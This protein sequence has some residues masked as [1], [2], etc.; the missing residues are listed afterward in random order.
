MAAGYS[1]PQ[2]FV[3][4][5]TGV[6]SLA[7]AESLR[8][9]PF[10]LVV[11]ENAGTRASKLVRAL[12]AVAVRSCSGEINVRAMGGAE[13]QHFVALA[14]QEEAARYDCLPRLSSGEFRND[15]WSGTGMTIGISKAGMVTVDATG[16]YGAVNTVFPPKSADPHGSAACFAAAMGF[17]KYFASA[18]LRKAAPF[19]ESWVFSLESLAMSPAPSSLEPVPITNMGRVHLV[20]A[21]A[22]GSAFCFSLHLSDDV[23]ELEIVDR[24]R[25]DEPNQETTFFLSRRDAVR[26]PHK[27]Q[28]LA[29][30]AI[31]RG[32]QIV[33]HPPMDLQR[34]DSYLQ[35]RCDALVCAVDNPETRR[36][37]DSANCGVLFN[38]GLGGTRLDAGHVLVSWH[39]A[40]VPPLSQLYADASEPIA[41]REQDS[42]PVEINDDCSRLEYERMSLAAPFIALASGALLHALCR[43]NVEHRLPDA[44]Y[45]KLDLLGWQRFMTRRLLHA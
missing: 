29:R 4:E 10:W 34:G 2:K 12:T 41:A 9:Q 7:E 19:A 32:L 35:R 40:D 31:R 13:F 42:F 38:A 8:R 20:G 23:S 14:A 15:E 22:I 28:E 6:Q 45:I 26:C 37:L 43:L 3:R 21:G 39:N 44:N 11:H 36:I 30:L 25:Y 24:E 5:I 27:A 33:G 1:R 18:V 16:T 17:A